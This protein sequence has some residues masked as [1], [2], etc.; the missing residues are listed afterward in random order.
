MSNKSHL[1][2]LTLAFLLS[3]ASHEGVV[4][5]VVQYGIYRLSHCPEKEDS[6]GEL[7]VV[8]ILHAHTK[9]HL[10]LPAQW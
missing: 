4:V 2:L 10:T 3:L 8:F 1:T 6:I 5:K 7:S 9:F